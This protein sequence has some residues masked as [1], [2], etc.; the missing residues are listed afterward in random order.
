M[1]GYK[2]E[3]AMN[4][5]DFSKCNILAGMGVFTGGIG[6]QDAHASD[7]NGNRYMEPSRSLPVRTFD[8]IVAGGG[9]AGVVAAIAAA[10][11]GSKTML[12]ERKGYT[13]GTVVEGGTAIHSFYNLWQAF[14]GVKKRKVVKGIAEEII[15]RLI[16][17]GGTTGYPEM[18]SNSDYD[19]VCTAIDTEL[20]KLVSFEMLSEAGVFVAVNTLLVGAIM[21]GSRLKGVITESRSGREAIYAH[22]FIDCTA[23]GDLSAFA[24]ADYTI[25]QI[26]RRS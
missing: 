21:D 5:R 11:N 12:I 25:L 22:S 7:D 4:R 1:S 26:H 6:S 19:S 15:D 20:Y 24:G 16:P 10:R 8:V 9:T 13:G 3:I 2:E 18:L 17:L 14:P 23:Y